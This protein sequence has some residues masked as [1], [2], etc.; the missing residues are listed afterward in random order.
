MSIALVSCFK[1]E[2]HIIEEW[3]E[4]YIAEGVDCFLLTDNGSTDNYLPK[5]QR[6][7]DQKIVVLRVD[8]AKHK[9]REHL[10]AF[11]DKAK[12]FEWVIGVDLDEFIY[13]RKGFHT[14]KEYLHTV[15]KNISQVYIPWKI[16]G[17]N[18]FIEQPQTVVTAFVKRTNYDKAN[19]MQAIIFDNN[20]KFSLVKCIVRTRYLVQ[21]NVHSHKTNHINYI[22]SDNI[23]TNIHSNGIFSRI[24][25]QVLEE[26]YLHLNH[27][28]IQSWNFFS[29]VKM[30]RGDIATSS[31]ENVRTAD[32]FKAFDINDIDDN[33]LAQKYTKRGGC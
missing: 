28:A 22:T 11:L 13:A 26:S 33:E 4:H 23:N 16:F 20:N 15:D 29:S 21:I 17:S 7:I 5:I 31:S 24:N 3:I 30:T 25:E 10:N 6:Y 8:P 18:G 27:Y 14:I 12:T 32:Y 2:G 19:G 1:N 9:Q